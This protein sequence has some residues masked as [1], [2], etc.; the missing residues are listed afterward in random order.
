MTMSQPTATNGKAEN[1]ATN[2]HWHRSA[3][4]LCSVNC[5]IEIE[6]QDGRFTRIRGDKQ[7]PM[8]AGYT[9]QKAMRLDYYQNN[10]NRLTHPLRRKPDGTFERVSWETAIRE[11][12]EKFVA[13]R[14]TNG[15]HSM[16]YYGGGGQGNHLGGAHGA[17]GWLAAV[18]TRYVYT[19][20]AQEKTGG[21][22]VDGKLFGRQD[23]HPAEDVEHADYLIVIGANPWQSHGVPRARKVLQ[24]I[25]RD[26]QRTLVVVDPRRTESA[27]K[28]DI[29]VQVRPGG[30]AHLMLAMLGT[31]VQEQLHNQQF[32]AQ[33]TVGFEE[34]AQRLRQIPVDEYAREAGVDPELVRQIARDYAQ[35]DRACVRT[36]LGLEHS[37]HSTL[38]TYLAKLLYLLTGHFGKEGTNTFH[39]A[40]GPIIGHSK[41]PEQGGLTTRVTGMKE[42]AGLFPPNVLPAEI[43]TDH[44]DRIRGVLVDS[45]NPLMTGADTQAYRAAFEKLEL[46][47]V[48]D[49]AMTETARMADYVLPAHTQFEKWEATFFNL[50]F[51]ENHF[52][53]RRP[54][55]EASEDT[56]PEPEVYRRL[57]VAM[58]ALPASFPLLRT[59]AKIDRRLPRLKLF[60][61]A[62][63]ATLKRNK[64]LKPYLPL[65]LHETLGYALPGDARPA[66]AIWGLCHMFVRRYGDECLRRAGIEDQGAGMAEALFEKILKGESGALI[67]RHDYQETWKFLAHRDGKIHL[68]IPELLDEVDALES[69]PAD[70]DYPFVLLAGERRSYNA[71]TIYRDEGWRKRDRE[72]A[73]K[74]HPDDAQQQ[75]LREG[76]LVACQ[77][78]RGEVRARV[79]FA[80]EMRRG[81]VSLPHGYGM[82]EPTGDGHSIQQTGPAVNMLTSA[83][84]CDA[85]AKTPFHKFVPVRLKPVTAAAADAAAGVGAA[86]ASA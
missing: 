19:S 56:L 64:K 34:V 43:D 29:H 79:E 61:I 8:S 31:I 28:A 60:P 62:L 25:A 37:L 50:E 14:D 83:D 26:P 2:G 38:N 16:A 67:S 81:A 77:S 76:D 78:A 47:V 63:A 54:V 46:L 1:G 58:G 27:E 42:I 69:L 3:C 30:D 40:F 66:A 45:H 23:C 10:P 32:I 80:D 21:F 5:G 41:E 55:V 9:C 68:A 24:D 51:P 75:G 82:E 4:I 72:G 65:V 71:N 22:W 57:L 74:I 52:H 85:I 48:I 20:L 86:G 36:D 70:D 73:L 59:I 12:A 6:V 49:V 84:H 33:H 35:A 53:L 44:P 13:L 7:H 17:A 11:V 39:T 18:G 15:G